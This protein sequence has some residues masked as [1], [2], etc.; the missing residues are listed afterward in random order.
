LA[1]AFA[2]DPQLAVVQ[3]PGREPQTETEKGLR[4]PGSFKCNGLGRYGFK[5]W[6]RTMVTSAKQGRGPEN[7][8]QPV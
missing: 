2:G 7:A 8:A 1:F 4:G 3:M 5:N 6:N